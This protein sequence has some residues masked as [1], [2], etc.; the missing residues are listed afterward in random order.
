MNS[1][2]LI[3]TGI[4][5]VQKNDMPNAITHFKQALALTPHDANLHT[6]IAHAYKK[7]KNIEQAFHHYQEAIRFNPSIAQAQHGLATLYALQ[8]NY[9]LALK[10]YHYALQLAPDFIEAHYNLGLLFIKQHELAAATTQFNN[11]LTLNPY[12]VN[13]AFYLGTLA[14]ERQAYDEAKQHF[15][16]VLSLNNEHVDA[17]VNLG[18]IALKRHENQQAID[19]F[20][21]ALAFDEH[22]LEARNNLAATFMHHDR[23]ENALMYYDGLIQQDM[24]NIEYHYNSGV[25][26]MALGHLQKA[27]A[28]FTT[29]LTRDEHHFAT[30]NNLAAIHLRLGE[31]KQAIDLLMRAVHANPNDESSRFMLSALTG[32]GQNQTASPDYVNNLFNNYAINYEQH[33][34]DILHYNLPHYVHQ[35]SIQHVTKALDLGCGTGLSGIILREKSAHLTGVD[36]AKKMLSQAKEKNIYDRLVEQEIVTFLQQDSSDYELIIALDVLPYFGDLDPLFA[37]LTPRL[38]TNGFF[39]FSTEISD[40]YDWHLQDTLRFCHHSDYI[41]RLCEKY[42]FYLEMQEPKI[43]RKQDKV[44]L[45]VMLYVLRSFNTNSPP[46]I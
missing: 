16:Y 45:T 13:A 39:I 32:Q 27:I 22:H 10:H 26:Q 9:A 21:Q 46:L 15:L 8:N 1:N 30:L 41:K 29:I 6:Y 23:F 17:L 20:T 24:N 42:N 35:L 44:D 7:L 34:Q 40:N 37:A 31:R 18:V 12:H 43:A 5:C 3:E 33:M 11:V 2:T 4:I 38:K 19:Y 14:L 28:H 36:I 25:A